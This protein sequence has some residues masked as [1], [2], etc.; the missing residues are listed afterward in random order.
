MPNESWSCGDNDQYIP[1]HIVTPQS[2]TGLS[3]CRPHYWSNISSSNDAVN[4]DCQC[5]TWGVH[6]MLGGA[7]LRWLV[8]LLGGR[9]VAHGHSCFSHIERLCMFTLLC[10]SFWSWLDLPHLDVLERHE[11]QSRAKKRQVAM[12]CNVSFGE[13]FCVLAI[14]SQKRESNLVLTPQI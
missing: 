13:T 4:E 11:I 10:G 3:I 2:S 9:R 14:G 7:F 8:C 5:H 6:E 12:K 1:A